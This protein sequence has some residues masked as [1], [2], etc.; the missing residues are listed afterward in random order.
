[1][2]I[3]SYSGMRSIRGCSIS[4]PSTKLKIAVNVSIRIQTQPVNSPIRIKKP[5]LPI[6]PQEITA[7]EYPGTVFVPGMGSI[8]DIENM[9]K[10]SPTT[11]RRP[12]PKMLWILGC[13]TFSTQPS[14]L[15]PAIAIFLR[16]F[17]SILRFPIDDGIQG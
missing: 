9:H 15:Y 3:V 5:S 6:I 1:M 16:L 17:L 13:E 4:E 2:S 7:I 12:R 14:H 8:I 11:R 10:Q